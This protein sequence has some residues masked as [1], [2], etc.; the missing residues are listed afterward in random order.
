MPKSKR[1]AKKT[2]GERRLQDALEGYGADALSLAEWTAR[3]T[4]AERSGAWRWKASDATATLAA[5]KARVDQAPASQLQQQSDRFV[6]VETAMRAELAV[7]QAASAPQSAVASECA[8]RERIG[9]RQYRCRN[10]LPTKQRAVAA[11]LCA[12]HARECRGA[13]HPMER[14]R[15]IDVP[16]DQALCLTC[17]AQAS[18]ASSRVPPRVPS[19]KVPGVV[20]VELKR[21]VTLALQQ[22]RRPKNEDDDD[23]GGGRLSASSRCAWQR[24]HA[25]RAFVWRCENRVLM[26]PT[27]R[28]AFLPFCGFHAPRCIQTYGGSATTQ[29]AAIERRNA[30]GLCRPHLAAQLSALPFEQRARCRLVDSEFDVPGLVECRRDAARHALRRHPLAPKHEPPPV[31]GSLPTTPLLGALPAAAF[32]SSNEVDGDG[33]PLTLRQRVQRLL[34]LLST[35]SRQLHTAAMLVPRVVL[36]PVVAALQA[37]GDNVVV[38]TMRA[39][40]WRW[41]FLRRAPTVATRIQRVFRGNRARRR[42]RALRFE[43]AA[44]QRLRASRVLQ[45]IARGFLG[46]VRTRQH[47]E[48]VA[49]AVRELQRVWRG[50]LARKWTRQTRAAAR[51]QRQYKAFR[52]RCLATA[53]RDEMAYMRALKRE[54]ERNWEQLQ[55]QLAVF[56]R[57]RARRVLRRHVQRWRLRREEQAR[58]AAE[59]LQRLVGAVKLQRAWR[60]HRRYRLLQRR[61]RSAQRLQARVRGWLTRHMWR[62]DPGVRRVTTFVSARSGLCYGRDV[63][64]PLVTRSYAVPTRCIRRQCAALVIQRAF[65]GLRGRLEANARWAAM[66]RRWEWLGIE[67]S[68]TQDSM[69]LGRARYALLLP[70]HRYDADP[71]RHMLPICHDIKA[72]RGFA[73]KFQSVLELI[74]DRDGRRG[75]SLEREERWRREQQRQQQRDAELARRI[76]RKMEGG[77][78][79]DGPQAAD[80]RGFGVAT[81]AVL[82]VGRALFPVGAVVHVASLQRRVSQR[83]YHRARVTA[84]HEADGG[85]TLFDVEYL[86]RVISTRGVRLYQEPRVPYARLRHI[87][88]IEPP[89]RSRARRAPVGT[90]IQAAI[91]Q[92]QNEILASKRQRLGLDTDGDLAATSTVEHDVVEDDDDGRPL[93]T[94]EALAARLRDTRPDRDLLRDHRDFVDFVFRNAKLLRVTWLQVVDRVRFGP[95]SSASPS[96]SPSMEALHRAFGF[97]PSPPPPLLSRSTKAQMNDRASDIETRL[98]A[99]GFRYDPSANVRPDDEDEDGGHA[100]RR[101]ET[102]TGH[103]LVPQSTSTLSAS[104]AALP[105][106]DDS[107]VPALAERLASSADL[108]R[109]VYELKT[110][111]RERHREK[112]IEVATRHARSFVCGFPA[113]GLVFSSQE[114]ARLHQEGVHLGHKRLATATPL[115][116]QFMH[117]YWPPQSPWGGRRRGHD[118]ELAE[119]HIVGYFRC[120]RRGCERVSF[121]T[122]REMERHKREVHAASPEKT[123]QDDTSDTLVV[124]DPEPAQQ[125]VKTLI[126]LGTYKLVAAKRLQELLGLSAELAPVKPCKEHTPVARAQPRWCRACFLATRHVAPPCRLYPTVALPGHVP[127][128]SDTT[129]GYVIFSCQD[130]SFCPIARAWDVVPLTSDGGDWWGRLRRPLSPSKATIKDAMSPRKPTTHGITPPSQP[131]NQEPVD[132]ED[133]LVL[134]R[135]LALCR[136]ANHVDWAFGHA[137]LERRSPLWL[138]RSRALHDDSDDHDDADAKEVVVDE[139]RVV[140]VRLKDVWAAGIVHRCARHVFRRKH[141]APDDQELVRRVRRTAQDLRSG[142]VLART[143][144]EAITTEEQSMITATFHRFCRPR[145]S[146]TD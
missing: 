49:R 46:R 104:T 68:A 12:W 21:D 3:K 76:Q 48:A 10:A 9:G 65:R 16:N 85:A 34:T 41:R 69:A 118:D 138:R 86:E 29:C 128:R 45:R 67:P 142:R 38:A 5:V 130:D 111:P 55:L 31:S 56:R 140:A 22:R 93:E 109:L 122:R 105:S 64:L 110:L 92:L 146:P 25:E 2:T 57:L 60:R 47:R 102:T 117:A 66:L 58:L 144:G 95:Q 133:E 96:P 135:V 73:Y 124:R 42:V 35:T 131:L 94:V 101:P 52:Q 18:G 50:A 126:W 70:A 15:A 91:H 62:G 114:A 103:D 44:L 7:A 28:G 82:S 119:S 98:A 11:T 1:K 84:V 14:S 132:E 61:Y 78:A 137:V 13:E 125:R 39:L 143:P 4:Q 51:I 90:L 81:G 24:E 79:P 75:W 17:Y 36:A 89:E 83:R 99:L 120:S 112:I 54:A 129:D 108:H 6:D 53:L 123:V 134:L 97:D 106:R 74:E 136:D 19:V 107:A 43:A 8:W 30:F 59:R 20:P 87:P 141:D 23:G 113:C 37:H 71:R 72:D 115:V 40:V 88:A 63:L 33:G 100:P 139:S 80:E 32:S 77:A 27:L 116:D 26:H 121:R 145:D 127:S